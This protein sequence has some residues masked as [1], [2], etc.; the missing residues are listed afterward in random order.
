MADDVRVRLDATDADVES[1]AT[2]A[3]QI[4]HASTLPAGTRVIVAPTALRRR[5][6]L[7]RFLGDASVPVPKAARCAALLA[8]GYVDVAAREDGSA[9]GVVPL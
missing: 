7:R 9:T 5:G 6:L 8:R 3:T 1:A 4:P 2:V